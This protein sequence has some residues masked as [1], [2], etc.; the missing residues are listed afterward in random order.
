MKCLFCNKK[1]SITIEC[2]CGK[3]TCITC[4]DPFLHD[5]SRDYKNEQREKL[6]KELMI[7]FSKISKI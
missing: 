3:E 5:C 4:R 6:K 7:S 2:K 1:C